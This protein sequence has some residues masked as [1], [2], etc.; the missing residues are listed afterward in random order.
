VSNVRLTVELEPNARA[1][2]RRDAPTTRETIEEKEPVSASAAVSHRQRVGVETGAA[3]ADL[4]TD[5]LGR[6]REMKNDVMLGVGAP[7]HD[8]V[9][10]ELGDEQPENIPLVAAEEAT[11]LLDNGLT[12]DRPGVNVSWEVDAR[13]LDDGR[14]PV[15]AGQAI[16]M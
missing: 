5:A 14:K 7:V 15:V 2:L 8:R 13:V 9:V 11:E 12:C 16:R 1:V 10:D 3:V 4:G 6:H